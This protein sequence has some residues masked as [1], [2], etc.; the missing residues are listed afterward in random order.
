M[1]IG[2]YSHNRSITNTGK[3]C[4]MFTIFFLSEKRFFRK[5]ESQNFSIAVHCCRSLNAGMGMCL[6]TST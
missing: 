1:T 2:R 4:N 5:S 3:Y 6:I